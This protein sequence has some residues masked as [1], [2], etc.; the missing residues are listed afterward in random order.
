MTFAMSYSNSMPSIYTLGPVV[1]DKLQCAGRQFDS[2]N[3]L[4]NGWAC[5]AV[6]ASDTLG[7]SQVSRPIRVCVMANTTD[8]GCADYRPLARLIPAEPLEIITSEALLAGNTP[9]TAGTQ[10]LIAGVTSDASAN[11]RWIV[12]PVDATGTRFSLRGAIG[13]SPKMCICEN[14]SCA[15]YSSCPVDSL[16]LQLTPGQPIVVETVS[17]HGLSTD[18][19]VVITG[20]TEQAGVAEKPWGIS[21]IDANHFSLLSSV[22]TAPLSPGGHMFALVGTMPDCTGTLVKDGVDGGRPLVD[23]TQPCKPWTNKNTFTHP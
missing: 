6:K 1:A 11:G 12:D 4:K 9:I 10:V 22:A 15:A 23:G 17:P 21:V 3:N 2:S 13:H 14:A 5:L 7:N 16:K 18:A 19:N 8:K 20:N